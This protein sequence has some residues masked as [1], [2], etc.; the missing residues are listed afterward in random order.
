[1]KIIPS[2]A[3]RKAC[4][5]RSFR[6]GSRLVRLRRRTIF[7][8]SRPS[9]SCERAWEGDDVQA[10]LVATRT[11][12]LLQACR[13]SSVRLL[14]PL[15]GCSCK[16][17]VLAHGRLP[18]ATSDPAARPALP[19]VSEGTNLSHG[20]GVPEVAR[21]TR[22]VRP[23]EAAPPCPVR[24]QRA[25]PH[26]LYLERPSR[27]PRRPRAIAVPARTPRPVLGSCPRADVEELAHEDSC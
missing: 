14:R 12:D 11:A 21:D 7:G 15:A 1:M 10:F 8:Q 2:A 5:C 23:A 27:S 19:S 13:R 6:C 9:Q 22:G 4:I 17:H 16:R 3:L 26:R 25:G 20:A 18:R 24:P